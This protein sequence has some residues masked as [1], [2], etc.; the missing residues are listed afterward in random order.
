ML[1]HTEN[2]LIGMI[3]MVRSHVTL[4]VGINRAQATVLFRAETRLSTTLADGFSRNPGSM[5]GEHGCSVCLSQ[6]ATTWTHGGIRRS[7]TMQHRSILMG[8]QHP[9]TIMV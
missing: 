1:T 6:G 3:S 5:N 2:R 8:N 7:P 9:I 4:P